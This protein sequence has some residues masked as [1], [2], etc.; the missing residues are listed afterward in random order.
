MFT[1]WGTSDS[2]KKHADGVV[3]VSTPSHGGFH[4]DPERNAKVH[5]AWRDKGGWYEEDCEWA[6][7]ALTFPD[8]FEPAHVE[9][10]HTSAKNWMP[11]AYEKVFGV[12]VTAEESHERREQ[13]FH[14]A[15][16]DK[17]VVTAA[18][19]YRNNKVGRV[20]VPEGMVGVVARI[21]GNGPGT[22]GNA[23]RYFLVPDHE[24]EACRRGFVVDDQRH[25]QWPEL[26]PGPTED[27]LVPV[28]VSG[29]MSADVWMVNDLA[30]GR[31]VG[32][33]W[34]HRATGAWTAY[35]RDGGAPRA[36]I[37]V[38]DREGAAAEAGWRIT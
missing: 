6:I 19:G 25:P 27:G 32:Q 7:V 13:E 5:A 2:S 17:L 23:E 24:Y 38:S 12:P 8:L 9:K 35:A 14:R 29:P 37:G 15:N 33:L 4:L 36:G 1:P 20:P 31:Q 11:D 34:R 18:W 16:A 10:A 22:T 30:T 3:E 26:V 28:L 21:G